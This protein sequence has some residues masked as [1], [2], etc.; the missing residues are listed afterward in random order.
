M[1]EV[2]HQQTTSPS[3]KIMVKINY[4]LLLFLVVM[5]PT[6]GLN[7]TPGSAQYKTKAKFIKEEC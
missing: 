5:A 2:L 3:L 6:K 4:A 7:Y 1:F